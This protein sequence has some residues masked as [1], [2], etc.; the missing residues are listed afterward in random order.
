MSNGGLLSNNAQ[1]RQVRLVLSRICVID[2]IYR[3]RTLTVIDD[4]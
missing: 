3:R 2:V 1:C 4:N